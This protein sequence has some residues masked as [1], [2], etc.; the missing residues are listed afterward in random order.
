ML[1]VA[2]ARF[3]G[4]AASAFGAQAM[5]AAT[6]RTVSRPHMTRQATECVIVAE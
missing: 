2:A 6:T 3:D 4:D 5:M 1:F